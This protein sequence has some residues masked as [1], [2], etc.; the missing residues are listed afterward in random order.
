MDWL[1]KSET[2]SAKAFRPLSGLVASPDVLLS[3]NLANTVNAVT[4]AVQSEVGMG[5]GFLIRWR[6]VQN[7]IRSEKRC[8]HLK[9]TTCSCW[10]DAVL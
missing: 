6:Q 4:I 2:A 5:V 7:C 1:V 10:G 9:K 8:T 3:L